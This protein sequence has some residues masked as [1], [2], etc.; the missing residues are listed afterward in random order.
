MT[1]EKHYIDANSL[2]ANSFRLADQIR[3]DD[4]APTHIIGIWRGGAPVGIA[5]QEF[6]EYHGLHAD[7]IAVRTSSYEAIDQQAAS[8]RVFS[9]SYLIKV[10]NNTDRLLIVDDVFDSGRSIEALIGKLKERCRRNMPDTVKIA[11]VYWKP[12]RNKTDLKPDYYVEETETWLVF[13]HELKGLT[14]E[15][16][17][18]NKVPADVILGKGE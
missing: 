14:P 13:P 2:L 3:R 1:I 4:F 15:E 18:A 8:V 10:L 6:L 5:V 7:H 17:M 11:T 12:S 9:I 16:I